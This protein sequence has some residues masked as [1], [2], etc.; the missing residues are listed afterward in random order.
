MKYITGLLEASNKLEDQAM[1]EEKDNRYCLQ[2]W[3]K[4]AQLYYRG[5]AEAKPDPYFHNTNPQTGV[6]YWSG[7]QT[8]G[9]KLTH[10][11]ST[12][13]IEYRE[14]RL[15]FQYGRVRRSL[16]NTFVPSPNSLWRGNGIDNGTLEAMPFAGADEKIR[17]DQEFLNMV[18][19]YFSWKGAV[20]HI[21]ADVGEGMFGHNE[22]R[23][24]GPG[25]VVHPSPRERT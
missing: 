21:V 11:G 3:A 18:G 20:W 23:R 22:I 14:K 15:H 12:A 25:R 13:Y 7:M 10:R 6:S 17:K 19:A 5:A 2:C 24:E 4:A 8:V 16:D 9:N 1:A